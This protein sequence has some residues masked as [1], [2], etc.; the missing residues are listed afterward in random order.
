M[1][2]YIVGGIVLSEFGLS[3]NLKQ[4]N[5][6][7]VYR[8]IRQEGCVSKQTITRELGLSLPTVTQNIVELM[9]R[10]LVCEQ[11]FFGN[12]GGRRAKGY[13]VNAE[14]KIAVGVDMNK[15][16]FSVAA[17]NLQGKVIA[18]TR[19]YRDF[20]D[21]DSYYQA[22]ASAVENL[23]ADLQ[24]SGETILGVG[25]AVQ[26]IVTPDRR[27]VIYGNVLGITGLTIDRAGKFIPYPKGL[28]HD[29]D[30]AAYAEYRAREG[31]IRAV[32]ISL[33][34]NLGGAFIDGGRSEQGPFGMARIEHMTLVPD[35]RRCY[36]GKKGC[37]DAYCSTYL[38]TDATP[39]NR[40]NT[41]FRLL[42]E[43]DPD[44]RAVWD[45]YTHDL[46]IMIN[47]TRMMFDCPVI[48]GGY[49]AEYLD[50][51][52]GEIKTLAYGR[53]SFDSSGDYLELSRILEE[54]IAVGAALQF[55][56]AFIEEI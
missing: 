47:N 52:L 46:A 41:F 56:D 45:K 38:L 4:L 29:S 39:D 1:K 35:G 27:K 2:L 10:G 14:A 33:S 55:I 17:L 9:E 15:R 5:R 43:G 18:K 53:N 48:L 50:Q 36:C 7:R 21:S 40:L 12:T 20:E 34:T 31:H 30:M 13:A 32:Y 6:N 28:F 22:V 8:L 26:G 23:I 25:L 54:P 19:K 44:I 16:H 11:G 3:A 37:A 42:E 51:H 24:I 49:L